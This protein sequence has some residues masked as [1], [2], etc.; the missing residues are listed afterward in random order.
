VSLISPDVPAALRGDPGR[1]RQILTNLV[2]NAVKFTE[3][4]EVV[5]RAAVDEDTADTPL[6]R[7]EVVDTGIG[8]PEEAQ[9]RL[10]QS[11]SQVDN[12]TTRRYGGTGLGLAISRRLAEFMGGEVGVTSR[13]GEGSTFWFTAK[14]GRPAEPVVVPAS[15]PV[16]LRGVRVLAVDDNATNRL[17]LR[18]HLLGWGMVGDEAACGQDALERLR[19]AAHQGTPYSLA[20]IDLQMPDMDGLE[21]ARAIKADAALALTGLV[22]LTSWGQRGEAAAAREAGIAFYLTK[23]VRAAH[24]LQCLTAVMSGASATSAVT[25]AASARPESGRSRTVRARVLVAEDNAVNQK[26]VVRVLEKRGIR[27]DVAGNGREALEALA[28]V[29]YELVL[30]D[31]QMPEVDGFEATRLIRHSEAGTERHIPIIALTANAMEG[32][33][34]RCLEAGMDDYV[35]KPI[36]PDDLYATID[37]L[38]ADPAIHE[39]PSLS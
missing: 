8:I 19:A 37:R 35:S 17:I 27:A 4:G 14:L 26:L 29:P 23:P 39:A 18:Q 7:F 24:L 32:D 1:L 15:S 25:T 36:R 2:G 10:F 33:R 31:C 28:R 12:S 30:M 34:E 6:V 16:V 11:F 3:R 22:L 9:G 38:L 13:P 5:V 20:L 21:L